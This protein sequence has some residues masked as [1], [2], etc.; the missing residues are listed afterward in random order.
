MH[1]GAGPHPTNRLG[2]AV[3]RGSA[4][5]CLPSSSPLGGSTAGTPTIAIAS[6]GFVSVTAGRQLTVPAPTAGT[7]DA[8]VGVY[9]EAVSRGE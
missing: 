6:S 2:G 5:A 8:H 7:R 9:G 4:R 1:H 3:L